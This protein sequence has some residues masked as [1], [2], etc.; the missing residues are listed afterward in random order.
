MWQFVPSEHMERLVEVEELHFT[1]AD[2][3]Q[4]TERNIHSVLNFQKPV[5]IFSFPQF[6]LHTR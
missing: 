6:R 4:Q 5:D 1:F 2:F 3:Q